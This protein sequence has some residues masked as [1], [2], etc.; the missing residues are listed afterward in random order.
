MKNDLV[1]SVREIFLLYNNTFIIPAYQRGYKWTEDHICH[2]LDSIASKISVCKNT[3]QY[4]CLQ[5]ITLCNSEE[6]LRVIDGQQRLI[7]LTLILSLL[8]DVQLKSRIIFSARDKTESFINDIIKNRT[9]GN[10]NSLD[11]EYISEAMAAIRKWL[12]YNKLPLDL[13]LDKVKLI[14]NVVQKN[15]ATAEEQTFANLN[16]I[17]S[18]LDGSDLLRAIFI[19]RCETERETEHMLGEEFDEMNKWCKDEENHKFL[20]RLVEINSFVETTVDKL[21]TYHARIAFDEKRYPINLIYKLFYV[22]NHNEEDEFNYVF[23]EQLLYSN[24]C[25][26]KFNDLRLL[27]SALKA[28]KDNREI[29]HFLGFLIFNTKECDFSQIYK[30]WQY[31]CEEFLPKIKSTICKMILSEFTENHS[32]SDL[33]NECHQ[34]Y[35]KRYN[36]DDGKKDDGMK[37]LIHI[38]ILQDILLCTRHPEVGYLPVEYFTRG[39]DDVEHIACQT[40]N[41]KDIHD[42][43]FRQ[44]YI[45][46][47]KELAEDINDSQLLKDINTL[48]DDATTPEQAI[49]IINGYGLNCAGNLVL[50]E[51][52][53]NRG[54]GNSVFETKRARIIESYF[55]NGKNNRKRYIRP[56]TLKVFLSSTNKGGI[57]RWTFNDIRNN[58]HRLY[59]ETKKWLEENE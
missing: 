14:V 29:Y 46:A 27:Y 22:V 11:E 59:E 56:Y 25:R 16:G 57:E 23:F 45:S 34:W 19:T 4:F 24:D 35:T 18:E 42:A 12:Q 54:Y 38:L 37:E 51:K 39:N 17:K 6:G 33:N 8:D 9:A 30:W 31:S 15:D 2:L 21:G 41:E 10:P 50:L 3:D 26:T 55:Q 36:I 5:N 44:L 13:F 48:E 40:P 53:L 32:L 28:W 43:E 58:T 1:Q 52:G 47:L 7:T 49:S 20:Q